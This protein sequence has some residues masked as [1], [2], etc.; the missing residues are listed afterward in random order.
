MLYP[1]G[2]QPAE[3]RRAL[4]ELMREML[5]EAPRTAEPEGQAARTP[6]AA[7]PTSRVLVE[8]C[9][10]GECSISLRVGP[11]VGAPGP[12]TPA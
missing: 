5:A 9:A 3:H 6:S 8:S 11:L 12:R 4:D 2:Y 1:N 7:Q 10:G